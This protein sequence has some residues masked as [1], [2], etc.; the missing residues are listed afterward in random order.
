MKT[1]HMT[2]D[3]KKSTITITNIE[4][5][6]AAEWNLYNSYKDKN[7]KVRNKRKTAKNAMHKKEYYLKKLE[8]DIAARTEFELI[9]EN[10][11]FATAVK[12]YR[13]V[14]ETGKFAEKQNAE[15]S[16][17]AEIPETTHIV[18]IPSVA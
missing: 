11:H 17:V 15:T 9:C 12:W 18:E 10:G 5:L 6:T 3:E 8:N 7:F 4:E 2:I 13:D 14:Y 1:T 16:R